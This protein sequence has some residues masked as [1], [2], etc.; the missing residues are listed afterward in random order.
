MS[1]N[2]GSFDPKAEAE[3]EILELMH[4]GNRAIERGDFGEARRHFNTCVER[5][6][7]YDGGYTALAS[8]AVAQGD[9]DDALA[10]LFVAAELAP[11][12]AE[13]R[14]QLGCAC[15]A[16]GRRAIAEHAFKRALELEP[17][18]PEALANLAELY[19][20]QGRFTESATCLR[21]AL[22]QNRDNVNALVAF[23]RM[24]ADLGDCD[25][26]R[27]AYQ[28]ALALDP[29]RGELTTALLEL[30]HDYEPSFDGNGD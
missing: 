12:S 28:R 13:I 20:A 18:H 25:A 11:T 19:R 8:V 27:F 23:G 21:A 29:T 26:A 17:A 15:F 9:L 4:A 1:A 10:M 30:D 22:E 5:F 2:N 14:N 7:A 24:S 16:A 3:F 6:P